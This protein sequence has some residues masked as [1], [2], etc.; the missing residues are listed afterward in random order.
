MAKRR[1]RRLDSR[2]APEMRRHLRDALPPGVSLDD[3]GLLCQAVN[4]GE[5]GFGCKGGSHSLALTTLRL[6]HGE[7]RGWRVE[8]LAWL[9][10]IGG[11][12][13]CTVNT[14]ALATV[15]ELSRDLW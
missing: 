2:L 12:C 6:T 8:L 5:E 4:A 14:A 11:H 9:A 15:V 3:V 1:K 13:D 7:L 10:D